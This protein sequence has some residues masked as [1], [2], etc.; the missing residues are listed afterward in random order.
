VP[1]ALNPTR[2]WEVEIKEGLDENKMYDILVI[3]AV[4]NLP[5]ATEESVQTYTKYPVG[6]VKESL[7]RL[8]VSGVLR[9]IGNEFFKI[10]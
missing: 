4:G 2:R 5:S 6:K 7:T 1:D 10:E 8:C 3:E 9:L